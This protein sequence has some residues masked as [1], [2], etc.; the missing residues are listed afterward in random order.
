MGFLT[1]YFIFSLVTYIGLSFSNS[2]SF[3]LLSSNIQKNMNNKY[4]SVSLFVAA[5]LF[6]YTYYKL[7]GIGY[8]RT[9]VLP[10]IVVS[11]LGY[12]IGN[13]TSKPFLKTY[14]MIKTK[15]ESFDKNLNKTNNKEI[16][17][18]EVVK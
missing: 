13:I 7:Y 14:D 15:I 10:M 9:M 2:I 1:L 11:V 18:A 5:L 12:N 16:Q 4:K 6:P 17:D 3:N 8:F